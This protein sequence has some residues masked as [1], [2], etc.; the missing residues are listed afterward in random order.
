MVSSINK[1]GKLSLLIILLLKWKAAEIFKKNQDGLWSSRLKKDQK[2]FENQ[3]LFQLV[4]KKG[5]DA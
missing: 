1:A 2:V 5:Q 4:N 3:I